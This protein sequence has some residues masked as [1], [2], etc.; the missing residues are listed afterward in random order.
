MV[1]DRDKIKMDYNAIYRLVL[2]LMTLRDPS[3]SRHS[4]TSTNS[5]F[6]R[7]IYSYIYDDR[8]IMIF[9]ILPLSVTLNDP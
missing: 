9:R 5:K 2:S 1:Q 6:I 4:S 7:D 8:L 3:W